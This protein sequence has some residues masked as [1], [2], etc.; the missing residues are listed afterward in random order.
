MRGR[1]V[2]PVLVLGGW[3]STERTGWFPW[4]RRKFDAEGVRHR[5]CRMTHYLFPLTE[6][7]VR[8]AERMAAE[9]GGAPVIVAHSFGGKVALKGLSDG[10]LQ[11]SVLIL[12]APLYRWPLGPWFRWW[13]EF[14][15]FDRVRERC[16]RMVVLHSREDRLV[17]FQNGAELARR[18]QEAGGEAQLLEFE[19]RGHFDPA[20]KC[21]ELPE[22]WEALTVLEPAKDL[23]PDQD[24]RTAG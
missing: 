2:E 13:N 17:P 12:V 6:P 21:F 23:R 19:G 24:R 7:T 8:R 20:A 14:A 4:L 11:A 1:A 5:F 10:R 9:L 16:G 3:M 18:F 22:V 15:D